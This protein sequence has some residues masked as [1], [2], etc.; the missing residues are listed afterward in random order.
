MLAINCAPW[1]LRKAAAWDRLCRAFE[2]CRE[3]EAAY[4]QGRTKTRHAANAAQRA[5]AAARDEYN[6][7]YDEAARAQAA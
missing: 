5:L 2:A 3:A 4:S 6:E 1:T 7:A